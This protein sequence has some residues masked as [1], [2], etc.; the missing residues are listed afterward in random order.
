MAG[1]K[2]GGSMSPKAGVK[3]NGHKQRYK[4]KIK[5]KK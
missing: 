1:R 4:R 2:R 3:H 5:V